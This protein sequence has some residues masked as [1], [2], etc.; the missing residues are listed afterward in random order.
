MRFGWEKMVAQSKLNNQS[1]SSSLWSLS[2][3]MVSSKVQL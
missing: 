2:S 1:I 3:G